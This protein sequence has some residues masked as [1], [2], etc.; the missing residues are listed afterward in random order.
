MELNI[1]NATESDLPAI[2]DIYND[3]ILHGTATFH[4]EPQTLEERTK[5]LKDVRAENYPCIVAEVVDDAHA[6]GGTRT[7]GWCNLGHYN[8]R[9]A[10]DGSAELS[11]YIHKDFRGKGIGEKLLQ[12]M[13]EE[14]RL[15]GGRFHVIIALDYP[16]F[17]AYFEKL[18]SIPAYLVDPRIVDLNNLNYG[19]W[20]VIAYQR[21]TVIITELVLGAAALKFVRGAENPTLQRII[22]ASLF[23]HPGFLIVDHIHFQYNGFMFGIL[24]WSLLMARNGRKLASG[25]LFAVLLNFKH[26][27]LYL[28]PAYFVYL[29]RSYCLSPTGTLLPGRFLSLANAV[30]LVFLASLG[31]FLLM[32]QLP[33]LLSRLFPFTRGLNHAYWAS[34]VWALVTALDRVLL[35]FVSKGQLSGLNVNASGVVS[36]SRGLVGDTIFAVLPTVKPMHTFAITVAFQTIYMGKL[37][38]NTSYKSFVTALT[39]CG[40]TSYMFGWH[41]HEKAILLVLVPLSLLAAEDNAY[42]RTFMIASIA[43]IYSLFPLL[44]TPAETLVKIVYSVLWAV[45]VLRP[46]HRQVYQFPQGVLAVGID[47][48]ERLYIAGFPLLQLFVTLFPLV[49]KK[50]TPSE[51]A[52]SENGSALEF[53]PLMLT[54]VYCAVGLVWA[55]ARLSIRRQARERRQYIYAK[56]VESQERQTYARKQQIKDALAGRKSLPTELRKDAKDLGRDLAFDEAQAEPSDHIDNEY[57]RAGILD[58]KI[59]VTTSRD[60]SSK[61]IQFAKEMR[62]VFPN[63][64]RINRGNYV[65]K[66]LAEAC[67]ANDV[68]DL[69]VLHE[70]RGVPD[71]MIVSH[72]PHGPT[73]YFTLHNVQLRHDIASYKSSTVSEQYPH[74]IFENFSSKLG[75]R[76]QDVL[77]YLFPVPKEDSKRVMTFSTEDDFISF[78]HH[79][80][81][82]IPPKQIQLAEVG[83]RFE[84]K[85]YEI[86]QGTIEQTEAEREWVLAHYSRTAKKRT[87]LSGPAPRPSANAAVAEDDSENKRKKRVRR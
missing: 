82:K 39:L 15:Q 70:H 40:F 51:V 54:S 1:R 56:S 3:Q 62:L 17:F 53:L 24:L 85:P 6:T 37:W 8:M 26:I 78:R 19:A 36:T 67:R 61:L 48:L 5:W 22:S 25:F 65:V 33:Q 45:F 10:Y 30:I 73:V 69:I 34:N 41:V 20:S 49:T 59:V 75:E 4:T 13:F 83:P 7:V 58:P 63:S 11:L 66:E 81:M 28:A 60:P 74:L 46:I 43:G 14:A 38:T 32:G 79:V 16:P 68:T 64:H 47:I 87:L 29:L 23:L 77:K 80:F 71:A 84:M 35:K 44:F 31:P 57:S 72:F 18:L 42:F 50:R 21:T 55:F 52:A 12:R 86:R 2:I 9:P 76:I 27:Y